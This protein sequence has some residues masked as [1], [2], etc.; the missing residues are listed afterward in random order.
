MPVWWSW[1]YWLNPLSY[2]IYGVITRCGNINVGFSLDRHLVAASSHMCHMHTL[3]NYGLWAAT[4]CQTASGILDRLRSGVLLKVLLL[5]TDVCGVLCVLCVV[6]PA[7][8][9]VM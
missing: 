9:L 8:N 2:M 5:I 4:A 1:F 7:A 3:P 6:C